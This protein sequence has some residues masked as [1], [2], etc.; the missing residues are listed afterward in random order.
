MLVTD[1]KLYLA[2]METIQFKLIVKII[3]DKGEVVY[4]NTFDEQIFA[5]FSSMIYQKPASN[6][7]SDDALHLINLNYRGKFFTVIIEFG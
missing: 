7:S 4:F 5:Q 2:N 6:N 1:I 3:G